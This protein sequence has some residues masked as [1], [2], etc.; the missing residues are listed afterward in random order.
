MKILAVSN[1]YP[2]KMGGIEIVA[3]NLVKNFRGAGHEVRWIAC[4]I[5]ERPHPEGLDDFPLR[6]W[7]FTEARLGFPYP[8]PRPRDLFS[9]LQHIRWCDVVH[10][11]DSLY[12]HNQFIFRAARKLKKPIV[13]TQHVGLVPY[14]QGYKNLLQQISYQS[15]GRAL[16][17]ASAQVV[18]V[19]EAVKDWYGQFVRFQRPPLVTPNGVD[20]EIFQPLSQPEVEA[21]RRALGLTPASPMLLFVGRFT[22][23]KGLQFIEQV[24]RERRDWSWVMVGG[25]AEQDPRSWSLPNVTVLPP[26]P[27]SELRKLYAAAD[28]VVLPSVGE[29][30]PL[31]V[32]EAMGCG[33]PVVTCPETARAVP[34]LSEFILV[35]EPA[36]GALKETMTRALADCEQLRSLRPRLVEFARTA[37][38]WET[39]AG[40]YCDIFSSL[41]NS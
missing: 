17:Q 25:A 26:Q 38:N 4:D 8:L 40:K 27:Q 12:F 11:H 6:A 28:L 10:L 23:K 19:N 35:T 13:T 5:Q 34:G 2:E 14:R 29:G 3:H 32:S 41:Q 24:A 31:V 21:V 33:T 18:F 22:Q 20:T 15:I 9:T 36:A 1:Y 16:L 39:V 30:F 37:L 7:N